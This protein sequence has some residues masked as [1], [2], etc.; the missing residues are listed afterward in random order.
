M[1]RFYDWATR[2]AA[3]QRVHRK[4]LAAALVAAALLQPTFARA[5]TIDWNV[6][7][8][9]NYNSALDPDAG[10]TPNWKDTTQANTTVIP[11]S[12]PSN[13]PVGVPAAGD[14]A[15]VRNGGT[16][17]ITSAISNLTFSVGFPR[18]LFSDDGTTITQTEVGGNGTVNMTGGSL[19][20]SGANGLTLRLGGVGLAS[21][22]SPVYT[23][24]FTQS[25]GTVTM[26]VAGNPGSSITIGTQGTTPSPTSTYNLQGGTISMIAGAGNNN[27]IN[28][29]NGTFNM[30]GGSITTSSLSGQRFITISSASGTTG[31]EN[32]ANAYFSGGTVNVAGGVRMAPNSNSKAFVTISNTAD[33]KMIGSD[34]QLGANGTNAYAQVDMSGGS[35]AIGGPTDS[36]TRR[37]IIGDSAGTSTG[38]FNL[39]GG[40]VNLYNSLV[41]VNN[42]GSKGTLN[43]T[44]GT[45]TVR[46]VE[47][48][49]N[50]GAYDPTTD[51]AVIS[52][53]G[54]NALF[55][56]ADNASGSG[57]LSIGQEGRGRFEVLQGEARVREI[58]VSEKAT[59]RATL[60]V[61]GG[62]LVVQDAL[63]R[64]D[65]SAATI[66]NIILTGGELELTAPGGISQWQANM[67]LQGTRLDTKPGALLQT[68]LGNATRPGNFSLN[69]GSI[70]DV[71]IANGTLTGADNID[72]NNGSAALNGGLLN[73]S[74]LGGY[75]PNIGDEVRIL[76]NVIN[77][78][79]LGSV[80]VSDSRWQPIVAASGT[81][82]HLIYVPE[83]SSM[84]LLGIGL[85][86]LSATRRTSRK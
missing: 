25:G 84:L 3:R 73:I 85:A 11:V 76:R 46:S 77:G 4:S 78:V 53:N 20:G 37:L 44:G 21:A 12:V 56:Q 67:D 79:T 74:L 5:A 39:S 65:V 58:R 75:T 24:T 69:T 66:P 72:V 41:V 6:V 32:V 35:L 2:W 19:T 31:N 48:N 62:K 70:W 80:A 9:E 17:T 82:I 45:L 50:A 33:I 28:V 86:M 60:K 68:N 47:M 64:T 7:G 18:T 83:P 29:R 55:I 34:F 8:P 42:A 43:Q 14:D 71:D 23:G 61:A 36:G 15:F 26:G 57:Q 13:A 59:S 81:E 1:I 51:T 49:R 63:N 30:T 10:A 40:A 22:G 52:I 27:G 16:A 38:V 54:P